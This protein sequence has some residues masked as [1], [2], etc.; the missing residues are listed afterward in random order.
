AHVEAIRQLLD[1]FPISPRNQS[2]SAHE[3]WQPHR[4]N[5]VL[6][7]D[8][9]ESEDDIIN[10]DIEE[11]RDAAQS[12]QSLQRVLKVPPESTNINVEIVDRR[13]DCP[14]EGD[15][16]SESLRQSGIAS[17][18]GGHPRGVIQFLPSAKQTEFFPTVDTYDTY[19]RNKTIDKK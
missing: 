18:L 12:I 9:T 4:Q 6:K 14:V 11:L 15:S 8:E 2:S 13:T 1:L 5:L 7:M 17:R 16:S 3:V 10:T 19:N